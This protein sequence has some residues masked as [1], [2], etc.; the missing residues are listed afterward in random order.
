MN[1]RKMNRTKVNLFLDIALTG[2]FLVSLKP[3]LTGMAI[4]EWLGLAIGVALAI[5]ML[6]HW[7]WIVAVTQ[8][9]FGKAP[10]QAQLYYALD[11]MLLAGFLTIISSGVAMSQEALPLFDFRGPAYIALAT[12]HKYVSYGT[13]TLLIVKLGLHGKWIVN[14]VQCHILGMRP[15]QKK[16]ASCEP[17]APPV[18]GNPPPTFSRRRFLTLSGSA[19]CLAFL[20]GKCNPQWDAEDEVAGVNALTQFEPV[21]GQNPTIATAHPTQSAEATPTQG[22]EVAPTQGVEVAPTQVIEVAPTQVV[23]VAPTQVVEVAPTVAPPVN[24]RCPYGMVNDPYPGRCRRYTDKNG[25]GICDYS[26]PA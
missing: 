20:I 16:A 4:H 10:Q 6:R 17:A 1:N 24:T 3:F 8:K 23:E 2:A 9:L 13:L 18:R 26:E 7:P 14:A 19:V 21:T 22:V 5:H 15:A 11:A 12:L 25:N